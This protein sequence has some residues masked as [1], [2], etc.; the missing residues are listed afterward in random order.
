[1]TAGREVDCTEGKWLVRVD[2]RRHLT[3]SMISWLDYRRERWWSGWSEQDIALIINHVK[4]ERCFL[5]LHVAFL[6]LLFYIKSILEGLSRHWPQIWTWSLYAA[7]LNSSTELIQ[8]QLV[9]S[10]SHR[11]ASRRNDQSDFKLFRCT[12]GHVS[13]VLR[14]KVNL[15]FNKVNPDLLTSLKIWRN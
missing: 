3:K 1:M 9:S 11:K 8:E 6:H 2:R 14:H 13:I 12:F 5:I 7:L 10:L 15:S 4:D